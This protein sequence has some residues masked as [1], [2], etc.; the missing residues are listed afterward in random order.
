MVIEVKARITRDVEGV[1]KK[2]TEKYMVEA[3]TCT[4]AEARVIEELTPYVAGG[5]SLSVTAAVKSNIAEVMRAADDETGQNWYKVKVQLISIDEKT[6]KEKRAAV[7]HLVEGA[8][9]EEALAC[10]RRGMRGTLSDYEIDSIAATAYLDV[11]APK[12]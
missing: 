3:M 8:N 10:F 6:G 9:F 2:V 4:E 5:G 11:F 1:T 12:A 7:M